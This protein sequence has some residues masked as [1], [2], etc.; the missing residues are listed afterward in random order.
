MKYKK[1]V[2]DQDIPGHIHGILERE[3]NILRKV[4]RALRRE[5]GS[6]RKQV[7]REKFGF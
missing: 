3:A 1:Q 6:K 4:I 2:S 5:I 7:R